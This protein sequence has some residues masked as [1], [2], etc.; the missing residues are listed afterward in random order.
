[1]AKRSYREAFPGVYACAKCEALLQ[2]TGAFGD[3]SGGALCLR[4]TGAPPGAVGPPWTVGWPLVRSV[5]TGLVRHATDELSGEED[6][7]EDEDDEDGDTA[8][9][10][11]DGHASVGDFDEDTDCMSPARRVPTTDDYDE[12]G[13]DNFEVDADGG[14]TMSTAA[15]SALG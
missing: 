15:R 8:T 5:R 1:M 4:C 11:S 7:D 2:V 13:E 9:D 10:Y 12:H 3:P 6:S 14:D